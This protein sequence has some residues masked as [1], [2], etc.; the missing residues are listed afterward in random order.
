MEKSDDSEGSIGVAGHTVNEVVVIQATIG[1]K[2]LIKRGKEI[3]L[4]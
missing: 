3:F 4:L 2:C 1:Y